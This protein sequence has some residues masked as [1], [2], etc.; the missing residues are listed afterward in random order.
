MVHSGNTDPGIIPELY[1]DEEDSPMA[2]RSHLTPV[3]DRRVRGF[4]AA[5]EA[6]AGVHKGF[7]LAS[8]LIGMGFAVASGWAALVAS[9]ADLSTFLASEQEHHVI[10]SRQDGA[11]VALQRDTA[12]TAARVDLM[13][14]DVRAMAARVG[15]PAPVPHPTVTP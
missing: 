8:A 3:P 5:W 14:Q 9:K 2:Q 7:V 13:R 4:G 1:E 6:L 15:I 11:I 12:V 10:H